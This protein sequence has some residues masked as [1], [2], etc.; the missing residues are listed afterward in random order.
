HR[1]RRDRPEERDEGR[2]LARAPPR[3]RRGQEDRPRHEGD[4]E[5][6]HEGVP[7]RALVRGRLLVASSLRARRG[8]E[9]ARLGALAGRRDLEFGRARQGGLLQNQEGRVGALWARQGAPDT[10]GTVI[11]STVPMNCT[12]RLSMYFPLRKCTRPW[13]SGR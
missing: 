6:P 12:R 2:A 13:S 3:R 8:G 4:R 7:G 9:R 11:G 5:R 1:P 10:E